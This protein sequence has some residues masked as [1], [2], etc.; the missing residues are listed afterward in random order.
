MLRDRPFV[1]ESARANILG[2]NLAPIMP[3]TPF[4]KDQA[5][6]PEQL[7]AMSAAFVKACARLRLSP[8]VDDLATRAVAEKVIGIARTGVLNPSELCKRAL[9]GLG[10]G[11][12]EHDAQIAPG[13]AASTRVDPGSSDSTTT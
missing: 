4:L 1:T 5:F 10:I 7:A 3:I 6:G 8:T 2:T 9:L 13:P 11:D 12:E